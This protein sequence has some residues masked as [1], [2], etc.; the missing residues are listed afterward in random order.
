MTSDP[1][2]AVTVLA[3][4]LAVAA[5]GFYVRLRG[6][7]ALLA[8]YTDATDPE[9]AAEHGGNAVAATGLV[10]AAYGAADLAWDLPEWTVAGLVGAATVGAFW[11]AARA[12]GR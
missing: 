2:A 7:P 9:Y 11:A 6:Q 5:T 10:V 4:G 12:Q 1:A 3:V 8:N